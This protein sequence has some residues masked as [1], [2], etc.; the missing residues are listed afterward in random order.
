M[1]RYARRRARCW[2]RCRRWTEEPSLLVSRW[3]FGI[4]WWAVRVCYDYRLTKLRRTFIEASN[5]TRQ[6]WNSDDDAGISG[7]VPGISGVSR[8]QQL[9]PG[10]D[11]RPG[12]SE[13]SAGEAGRR[14]GT[15]SGWIA[16]GDH[17]HYSSSV[18]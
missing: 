12:R 6:H 2:R 1:S 4:R 7:V 9:G 3:S 17:L 11:W 8:R 15:G 5:K 16:S 13:E 14:F 10:N 18:L